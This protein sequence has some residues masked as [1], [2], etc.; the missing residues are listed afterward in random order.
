MRD[1]FAARAKRLQIS[2]IRKMFE[3]AGPDSI[4]LG[5][6]ELDFEPSELAMKAL[7]DAV[8]N[9]YNHYGP[10]KGIP[11]LRKALAE[12]LTRYRPDVEMD[13]IIVTAGGTQGLLVSAMTLFD[14]GDEVLTPDPGFVIYQPHV[15]MCGAT[16]LRYSLR[17]ENNFQPNPDEI[18]ELITPRTK[19]IIVNSPNNPTSGILEPDTIKALRDIAVENELVIISD[20]VYDEIIFEGEHHSLLN[21]DYDN[22]VYI[23]SFSKTFALTGWRLGYMA[24]S[25][26]MVNQ[27]SKLQ[28]YNIACPPTPLQKAIFDV[29]NAPTNS[30]Q[31]RVDILRKRR[32]V[33]VK[34]LNDID[35]FSCLKPKGAFYAFPTFDHDISSEDFAME[36]VK[37][38]LICAPGSAFGKG[39]E[40]H[41][42]FS[43]ANSLEMIEKGMDVLEKVAAT[44]PRKN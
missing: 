7:A 35:G 31:E 8:H 37:S 42:R 14:H 27:L 13:N 22:V 9:G 15:I 19:A 40:G 3:M 30:V 12:R 28:Y 38:G 6:G 21:P 2:G 20:E 24:S 44:I 43:F 32:D 4:N 1:W 29:M 23:N 33:I 26:Y 39:G 18:Q 25:K 5:L 16:P 36:L 17:F 34:R 10:T 41:L 11:E